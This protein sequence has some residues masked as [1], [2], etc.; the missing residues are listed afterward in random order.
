MADADSDLPATPARLIAALRTG[1][2]HTAADAAYQ[3]VYE[4]WLTR[5]RW[6][7]EREALPL[8]VGVDPLQWPKHV[9]RY[10]LARTSEAA[11]HA[12]VAAFGSAPAAALEPQYLAQWARQ[13]EIA[14]PLPFA[15]ILEFLQQVLPTA[16][17][18]MVAGGAAATASDR[19]R[20]LGAALALVCRFPAACRDAN[21]SISSDT[22]AAS[23]LAQSPEWF[24][25]GPSALG[26]DDIVTLLERYLS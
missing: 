16:Q 14:L 5:E 25:Q 3:I 18:A 1:V 24:P 6:Q 2:D 21:G 7:L 13:H 26:R 11:L 17:A 10:D 22:L 19:E 4:T 8:L 23:V 20:V 15:R 9:E 12:L